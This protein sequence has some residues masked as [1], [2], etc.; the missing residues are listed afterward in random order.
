MPKLKTF[1]TDIDIATETR[2]KLIGLLNHQLADMFD[3]YSQTKY[4]HWNVRGPQFY[5]FH[6]LFD[7]LAEK[8]EM[9]IDEV[10]ERA[11]ALGGVALGTVR[12]SADSS[13]LHDFPTNVFDG[14]S[15]VEK[16]AG[17]YATLAASTRAAASDLDEQG[18][19][20]TTDL[21]TNMSREIDK[22]LWL[23]EA[24]LQK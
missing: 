12:M 5:Q 10:A 23:L 17:Q 6:K 15:L 11:T 3:L 1:S 13:R 2:E 16:L 18:D 21:F 9:Y 4:A 24:H 14:L 19:L 7:E 8:L 20:A 22:A